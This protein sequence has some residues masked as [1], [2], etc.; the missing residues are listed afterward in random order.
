MSLKSYLKPSNTYWGK[1]IFCGTAAIALLCGAAFVNADDLAIYSQEQLLIGARAVV[2]TGSVQSGASVLVDNYAQVKGN[3]YATTTA[4]VRSYA[5]VYNNL[6]AGTTYTIESGAV[7]DGY[8]QANASIPAYTIGTK[9]V[10]V[11]TVNKTVP[12]YGSLTLAAG[13]Y[14]DV[15]VGQGGKLYLSSGTY[16]FRKLEVYYDAKVYINISATQT[17]TLNVRDFFAVRDRAKI[18]LTN[19]TNTAA[20]NFYVHHTNFIDIGC[21][22]NVEGCFDIPNGEF[23]ILSR[24]YFTGSVNAKKVSVMAEANVN[25]ELA[26]D[27]DSDGAPDVIE[28]IAGTSPTSAGSKPAIV[29]SGGWSNTTDRGNML[30]TVDFHDWPGYSFIT[31]APV[32]L[33]YN[34]IKGNYSVVYSYQQVYTDEIIP[35]YKLDNHSEITINK[36]AS[37][38]C[39]TCNTT[40]E[41]FIPVSDKSRGTIKECLKLFFYSSSGLVEIPIKRLTYNGIYAEVEEFGTFAVGTYANNYKVDYRYTDAELTADNTKSRTIQ[42]A[43]AKIEA[44][45]GDPAAVVQVAM[46]EGTNSYVCNGIEV[47]HSTQVIGGFQAGLTGAG[48]GLVGSD[49]RANITTIVNSTSAAPVPAKPAFVFFRMPSSTVPVNRFYNS[50]IDGFRFLGY[51]DLVLTSAQIN[52]VANLAGAIVIWGRGHIKNIHIRNCVFDDNI[53]TIGGAVFAV[54][55][56]QVFFESC[57]FVNNRSVAGGSMPD[58]DPS[59]SG[60]CRSCAALEVVVEE[61]V[62]SGNYVHYTLNG[63]GSYSTSWFGEEKWSAGAAAVF[64]ISGCGAETEFDGCVFWNNTTSFAKNDDA[65]ANGGT[66]AIYDQSGIGRP[67]KI[68]NSTFNNNTVAGVDLGSTPK[69]H[70]LSAGGIYVHGVVEGHTGAFS[71]IIVMNSIL[72]GNTGGT[73]KEISGI[74]N[75]GPVTYE[76][77]FDYNYSPP[78]PSHGET[79]TV[80]AMISFSNIEQTITS[81][82]GDGNINT[83][84]MFEGLSATDDGKWGTEDDR[85]RPKFE[86]TSRDIGRWQGLAEHKTSTLTNYYKPYYY[87]AAGRPKLGDVDMGA[88]ESYI[89]ILCIGD[90]MTRGKGLSSEPWTYRA[91]L[92]AQL[93]TNLHW[94]VSF[95]GTGI[96]SETSTGNEVPL[97]VPVSMPWTNAVLKPITDLVR[98]QPNPAIM[99]SVQYN[100]LH[101]GKSGSSTSYYTQTLTEQILNGKPD[102]ASPVVIA[103]KPDIVLFM[104]G[105][106]EA[107]NGTTSASAMAT[108]IGVTEKVFTDWMTAQTASRTQRFVFIGKVPPHQDLLGVNQKIND[109]NT[110]ITKTS[111]DQIVN[112][113]GAVHPNGGTFSLEDNSIDFLPNKPIN[114]TKHGDEIVS[115]GWFEAIKGVFGRK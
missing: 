96:T 107:A 6:L 37:E 2:N 70:D 114:L 47:P 19:A 63:P 95:V 98:A 27:R 82:A 106:Y 39:R 81:I 86:S 25:G 110:A 44:L 31:N 84:P 3:V 103:K 16:N 4:L 14:Q 41:I 75:S 101:N 115:N 77:N 89:K 97:S 26:R 64:N 32:N 23:R 52:S 28:Y 12:S 50:T 92:S 59:V 60:Y 108:N 30:L 99:T 5:H 48:N 34:S 51:Q 73:L 49:P 88:Y 38:P 109:F 13:N 102:A 113:Y 87:D 104:T 74:T 33:S 93:R 90:D 10:T 62:G 91:S 71:P 94:N 100:T 7:V 83:D 76:T 79:Q 69:K 42:E 78:G 111:A 67:I 53:G 58:N 68:I 15:Y 105:S 21:D 22:A 17:I 54:N 55:C 61:P 56:S 24:A 18:S 8:K 1:N 9:T 45:T 65:T 66:V 11:G 35:G 112:I 85:L 40:T 46:A 29:T 57:C 36:A 80:N 20:V 43:F 72:W